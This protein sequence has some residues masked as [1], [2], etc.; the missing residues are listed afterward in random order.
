MGTSC[1]RSPRI[2][3]TPFYAYDR[4]VIAQQIRALRA[5]FHAR[6]IALRHEGESDAEVVRYIAPLVD[7]LDVASGRELS[8]ALTTAVAPL[9]ISFAGPGKSVDELRQAIAAGI[10]INIES[11]G[12]ARDGCHASATHQRTPV[13]VR[14][15]PTSN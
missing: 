3:H 2:G 12:V 5:C 13:C 14:V 7:G 9:D 10:V 8:V 4:E 1:R 6:G 11:P 15:N